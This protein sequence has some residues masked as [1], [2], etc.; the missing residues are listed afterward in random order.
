M[1]NRELSALHATDGGD[2]TKG[3][4]VY[5]EDEVS[6]YSEL[7]FRSWLFAHPEKASS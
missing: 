7:V 4:W 5:L 2:Y 3:T 1:N 6:G